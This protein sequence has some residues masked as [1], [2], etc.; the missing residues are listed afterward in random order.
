M[1]GNLVTLFTPG[2]QFLWGARCGKGAVSST[3]NVTHELAKLMGLE[4]T[5]PFKADV[6]EQPL[7]QHPLPAGPA[8]L[9]AFDQYLAK[10]LKTNLT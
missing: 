3:L 7:P 6:A 1:F 10:H 5:W 4:A 2:K 8:V 9:G